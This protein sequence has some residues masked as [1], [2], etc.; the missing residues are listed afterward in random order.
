MSG[1]DFSAAEPEGFA[2]FSVT[3]GPMNQPYWRTSWL[4]TNIKHLRVEPLRKLPGC[5]GT[6]QRD[7]K[8]RDLEMNN[9]SGGSSET[10]RDTLRLCDSVSVSFSSEISSHRWGRTSQVENKAHRH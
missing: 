9:G 7:H 8:P 1:I 3:T 10:G 6:A 5:S 2:A 4:L